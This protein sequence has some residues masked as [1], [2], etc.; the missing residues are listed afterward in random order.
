M[1]VPRRL[2]E[3]IDSFCKLAE[4]EQL[5]RVGAAD[6]ESICLRNFRYVEPSASLHVIFKRIIHSK[7]DTSS[8]DGQY[9]MAQRLRAEVTAGADVE[10]VAEVI[11]HAAFGGTVWHLAQPMIEPPQIVGDTLA[12][13]SDH[14]L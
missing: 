9:R 1:A 10:I 2:S 13:V 5:L 8:A 7:Q 6:F 12:E 3:R 14:D 4:S 11:G